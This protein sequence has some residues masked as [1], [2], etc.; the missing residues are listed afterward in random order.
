MDYSGAAVRVQLLHGAVSEKIRG[1]YIQPF[2]DSRFETLWRGLGPH[3]SSLSNFQDS[4]FPR[5]QLVWA[6]QQQERSIFSQMR[7]M[8]SEPILFEAVSK[9]ALEIGSRLHLY[10]PGGQS[11][12]VS[13]KAKNKRGGFDA[14]S[15]G[16]CVC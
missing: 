11:S 8:P 15:H 9:N 13:T 3:D 5:M 1:H 10:A 7:Q 2:F 6:N 14:S 4:I 16:A 12:S